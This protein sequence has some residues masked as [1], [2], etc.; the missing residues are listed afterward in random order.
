MRRRHVTRGTTAAVPAAVPCAMPPRARLVARLVAIVFLA[1]GG[2]VV[3][4][5]SETA[6]AYAHAYLQESSPVDGQVLASS[7]AEVRLRFDEAVS[8]GGRSIQLLDPTGK[9]LAIGAGE[10]ADGKTDTA[11]ASLPR[12]L[13]EGTYV[14]SWRVTSV[15]SHVVS[16]AFSFSVGH[17]SATAAPVEQDTDPVVP[18][19]AA[20]GRAMAY[21]G[22]ALALGGGMF[23]A[24]L[25]PAG[26]DDRRGRRVVWSG[27]AVLAAGTAVVLLV[28]GPYADGRSLITVFDPGLLGATL[29]TRLGY[30]LLARLVLVVVLGVVF[31][32]AVGRPSPAAGPEPAGPISAGPEPAGAAR[33]IVL[34]AVAAAGAVAMTLTWTLADHAQSGTQIWLAVPATSLHLLAMA[35]WLGGLVALA[36]CV[37]AP[38][39]KRGPALLSLEPA[40]PRFSRLALLCFAVIAGTGL[41][42]SWRQVGTWGALGG[43]DF[44]RLLLGKLA[45]VLGVLA[46]ASGARRFV[47]RRD[48][49]R[50]AAA[51]PAAPAAPRD[52][53][54]ALRGLR[55]S[56]A[57]EVVLGLVVVSITAVLVG[58]APARTSYAPP[59]DATVPFPAAATAS[60]PY[61]GLR[62]GSIQVKIE[63][64]RPGGNTADIYLIGRDGTLVPVPE[65]SGALE[66]RDRAVPALP[67]TVTA[68]EP[69]HYVAGSMSIPY[70]GEWALRLDIRVSDFDETRVR[71]PF[72]AH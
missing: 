12:D 72:T 44:G 50:R 29:S 13:A 41:Y 67:V 56:V 62:G 57:G 24:A 54:A 63:P 4:L 26:R 8:L 3:G 7:P 51:A 40:L 33:R 61:G 5:F 31:L 19:V 55:R 1:A 46:L 43:T 14:V 65:I 69:G 18:V 37:L 38:A 53:G 58:T 11:R 20:A 39:A 71:V 64:A 60:G 21:L 42:L 35:L 22:V 15:D 45:V 27:F 9:E 68:A 59:V 6:P 70:P 23:V 32:I 17:P 10:Y 49:A 30:A 36:V 2:L 48:R 28:Q 47:Q 25:W 66:S 34:P 16:G 52:P